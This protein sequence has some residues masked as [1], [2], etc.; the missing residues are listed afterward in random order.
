MQK[1]NK[2]LSVNSNT[3][4]CIIMSFIYSAAE[5]TQ[6]LSFWCALG[7]NTEPDSPFELH[8]FWLGTLVTGSTV[9]QLNNEDRHE[10]ALNSLDMENTTRNTTFLRCIENERART[11]DA[12]YMNLRQ[13]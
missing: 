4:L 8:S 9:F 2:H 3:I 5:S 13:V 6:G 11:V 12:R 1:H 7:L 10:L